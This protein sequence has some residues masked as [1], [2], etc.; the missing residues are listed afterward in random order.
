MELF[1]RKLG[2]SAG[3][4]LPPALLRSLNLSIGSSVTAEIVKGKLV[5]TPALRPRYRL[6]ELV[7]QC[8]PKAPPP[9]DMQAWYSVSAVGK[10]VV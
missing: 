9:K 4:I 5:L 10:E 7:A 8:D 6:T 3:I 2:N 1:I